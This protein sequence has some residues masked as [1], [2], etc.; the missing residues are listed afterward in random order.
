VAADL[1]LAAA[2]PIAHYVEYLTPCAYIDDVTVEP[3]V[4]DSEGYLEIPDRPGLGVT[5]SE[6]KLKRF[7][8][9]ESVVFNV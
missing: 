7:R 1:Q 6:E 5:L 3:F 2:L 9:K 8:G 4:L